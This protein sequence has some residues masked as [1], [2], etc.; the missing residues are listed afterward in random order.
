MKYWCTQPR[1]FPLQRVA[2]GDEII[3]KL[4]HQTVAAPGVVPEVPLPTDLVFF[5][6]FPPRTGPTK[7]KKKKNTWTYTHTHTHIHKRRLAS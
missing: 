4:P 6:F 5:I 7:Q 1:P 2:S 3:A